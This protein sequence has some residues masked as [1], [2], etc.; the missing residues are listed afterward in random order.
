MKKQFSETNSF[1]ELNSSPTALHLV[2][3]NNTQPCYNIIQPPLST[4]HNSDYK[5]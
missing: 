1:S 5:I 3:N 4:N 2:Y